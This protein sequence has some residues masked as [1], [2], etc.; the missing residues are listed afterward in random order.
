[1]CNVQMQNRLQAL[2]R[3]SRLDVT[4]K[5]ALDPIHAQLLRDG[6]NGWYLSCGTYGLIS[7]LRYYYIAYSTNKLQASRYVAA[8]TQVNQVYRAVWPRLLDRV[9]SAPSTPYPS[10]LTGLGWPGGETRYMTGFFLAEITCG[11][12]ASAIISGFQHLSRNLM[13]LSLYHNFWSCYS[14]GF[15]LCRSW[16]FFDHINVTHPSSA[17]SLAT[18]WMSNSSPVM[19]PRKSLDSRRDS[20]LIQGTSRHP[21]QALPTCHRSSTSR[22]RHQPKV[23]SLAASRLLIWS[24]PILRESMRRPSSALYSRLIPMPCQ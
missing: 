12:H 18:L 4:S 6:E 2:N 13:N 22:S 14:A 17:I 9:A 5:I 15:F 24:M 8:R 11:N 1:M 10:E 20:M 23:S 19:R 16:R 7:C 21:A 3:S